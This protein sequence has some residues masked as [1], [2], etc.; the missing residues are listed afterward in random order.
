MR[1]LFHFIMIGYYTGG[2]QIA[3]NWLNFTILYLSQEDDFSFMI[4]EGIYEKQPKRQPKLCFT[5]F[6]RKT[7][8]HL[9]GL[10]DFDCLGNFGVQ[11]LLYLI[12]TPGRQRAQLE[13]AGCAVWLH[14]YVCMYAYVYVVGAGRRQTR[15][16]HLSLISGDLASSTEQQGS[17]RI[18][19]YGCSRCQRLLVLGLS[20]SMVHAIY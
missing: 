6:A 5:C 2:S 13:A 16:G 1:K 11:F 17:P 9:S 14:V 10:N 4:I 15:W 19:K 12:L 8:F 7:R 20:M 18:R 3:M